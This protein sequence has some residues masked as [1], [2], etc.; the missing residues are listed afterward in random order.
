MHICQLPTPIH[1]ANNSQPRTEYPTA[2]E[3]VHIAAATF[4][5]FLTLSVYFLTT[6]YN[7]C[8][9][10]SPSRRPYSNVNGVD[11]PL[12]SSSFFSHESCALTVLSRPVFF[13]RRLLMYCYVSF[14]FRRSLYFLFLR[15]VM[16]DLLVCSGVRIGI[17]LVYT[18]QEDKDSEVFVSSG[19]DGTALTGKM[20]RSW[21]FHLLGPRYK[22]LLNR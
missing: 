9:Y 15:G 10:Y 7:Q 18:I 22:S 6:S 11:L 1:S 3:V 16:F 19:L 5:V 8:L 4:L 17:P 12:L 2:Q 21:C 20:E 14:F 13:A